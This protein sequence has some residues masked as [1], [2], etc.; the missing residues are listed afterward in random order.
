MLHLINGTLIVIGGE[1]VFLLNFKDVYRFKYIYLGILAY[2]YYYIISFS[3][4]LSGCYLF[5]LIFSIA[6]YKIENKLKQKYELFI[7]NR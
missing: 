3:S 5:L 4:K 7:I 1:L 2:S 6:S